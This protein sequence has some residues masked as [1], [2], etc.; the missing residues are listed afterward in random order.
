MGSV[1]GHMKPVLYGTRCYSETVESVMHGLQAGE[2]ENQALIPS[3]G[4]DFLFSA[5][6]SPVLVTTQR[7]IRR[8]PG[9]V[10]ARSK[11]AREGS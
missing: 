2:P 3:K 8:I 11:V 4:R 1:K 6:S 7:A 5:A 9:V 10:S